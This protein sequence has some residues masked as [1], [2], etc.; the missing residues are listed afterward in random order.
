MILVTFRVDLMGDGQGRICVARRE[1]LK[2]PKKKVVA[3]TQTTYKLL[4]K[5]LISFRYNDDNKQRYKQS[6]YY[7]L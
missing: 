4:A 5:A 1:K 6:I 2:F 3:H 7:T